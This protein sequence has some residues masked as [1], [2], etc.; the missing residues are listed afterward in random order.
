MISDV[1]ILALVLFVP[2][3]NEGPFYDFVLNELPPSMKDHLPKFLS[4][5]SI[6]YQRDEVISALLYHIFYKKTSGDVGSFHK[7][8]TFEMGYFHLQFESEEDVEKREL[9]SVEFLL[10]NLAEQYSFIISNFFYLT[11]EG[12]H[13][14]VKMHTD[15]S[16]EDED[17]F[18]EIDYDQYT[19]LIDSYF[20][21]SVIPDE[22]LDEIALLMLMKEPSV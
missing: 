6:E 16:N 7:K 11:E 3:E 10:Q 15:L 17:D 18:D 22:Y 9:A 4:F 8:A 19:N 13:E 1:Y 20:Y 21:K 5:K 12:L 2:Y 14:F